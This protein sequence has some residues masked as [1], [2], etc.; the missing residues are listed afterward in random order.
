MNATILV[1]YLLATLLGL[2]Y[3]SKITLSKRFSIAIVSVTF[4]A[5]AILAML[6][7]PYPFYGHEQGLENF[8]YSAVYLASLIG[9]LF[10]TAMNMGVA[11]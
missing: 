4:I 2:I 10:G 7:G 5:G 9:C 1:I 11:R 8:S 3:G 6:L